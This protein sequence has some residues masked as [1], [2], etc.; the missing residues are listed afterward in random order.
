MSGAKR[1]IEIGTFT[2]Y[3]ALCLAEG[4]P[5]DGQLVCLEKSDQYAA[6]AATYWQQAG[7]SHK[8]DLKIGLAVDTLTDMAADITKNQAFDFA[9]IDG[10]KAL[11]Q[12]YINC[13]LPLIRRNGFIMIDNTL[14]MGKVIDPVARA[15]EVDT[16][17]IHESITSALNDPRLDT[18]SL[19]ISDGL[20]IIQVL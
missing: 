2:G 16:R 15:T 7:V 14:W 18:H 20:T 1:G 9:F 13:L 19:M 10:D 4:L 11:Y 5:E 6:V 17:V 3:S 12:D 8:I